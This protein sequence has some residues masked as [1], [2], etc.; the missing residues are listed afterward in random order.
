MSLTD[1]A[2]A[3]PL[4]ISATRDRL[5][6]LEGSGLI[7]GYTVR[8][9]LAAL[10]PVI[11]ALVDVRLGPN[12]ATEDADKALATIPGIIDAHHLTGR[13]DMQLRVITRDVAEL[14]T[15]LRRL[16]TDMGAEETNTRLIL[17][18]L[19]PFPRAPLELLDQ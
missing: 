9:D 16:A 19:E 1:L 11:E 15:M 17:R 13:F 14:D 4:S 10:G 18:T 3:L 6:R 5:R 7:D 8:V 12:H 2:E